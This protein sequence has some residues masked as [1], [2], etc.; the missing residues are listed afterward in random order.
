MR[1]F[2]ADTASRRNLPGPLLFAL[3]FAIL[4][5]VVA[6]GCGNDPFDP[7]S[8]PNQAPV[9]RIFI[10]P[11]EAGLDLNPTSYYRRTF[12]WS[13]TDPDGFVVEYY[14]SIATML[15]EEAPWGVTTE[16]DTTMTF[17]TDDEG[18]A[19][20]LVKVACRDDRG[21]LSDT[22]SQFIP[23]K[24]FPP[25]INFQ[26]DF[27][28]FTWSYGSASL[29]FFA[30]DLDGNETM[31]DSIL[32]YL[33]TADT[34][35]PPLAEGEPGA[36]PNLRPVRMAF[37]APDEGL[38]EVGLHDIANPGTRTLTVA[39]SDEADAVT[40]FDWTW[41]SL[42]VLGDVLVL[43]DVTGDYDVPVQQAAMDSIF[44]PGNWSRYDLE[45]GLPDRL[46]VLTET[47]RQFPAA[48]WYTG[49]SPSY[50]LRDAVPILTDYLAPTESGVEAGRLL[51][52]CKTVVGS[53]TIRLSS[54]FVQETLGISQV[55]APATMFVIPID[56][57]ALPLI[58]SLPELRPM[59]AY[60]TA[61]GLMPVNGSEAIY[62]L[63]Y[64]RYTPRPPFEPYVGVRMPASAT[65]ET[66]RAVTISCQ[67]EFMMLEDVVSALRGIFSDEMGVDLP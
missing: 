38:F 65:G 15:G 16:T 62:Q 67:L 21:A 1:E 66:A 61:I 13:G 31:S 49:S 17:T 2:R 24:N 14:V 23:L 12:S 39:V 20:A 29:R 34:L 46:W 58:P 32:Y 43:D 8:V 11:N 40:K 28:T 6:G 41:E 5:A 22:A 10:S 35:L 57:K 47:L 26:A 25:V 59:S 30:I 56:K 33:D 48:F 52:A 63:E 9:A 45:A 27:D 64:H 60:G 4:M 54:V 50:N 42:P 44:G 19:M 53:T 7:D 18:D 37:Q 3:A 36:D 55:A 51:L